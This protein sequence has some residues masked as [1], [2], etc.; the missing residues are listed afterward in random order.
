[1][2]DLLRFYRENNVDLKDLTSSIISPQM[3]AD[4]IVLVEQ[5]VISGKIAKSVFEEMSKTGKSPAAIVE[6]KGLVQISDT[7]AIEKLVDQVIQDN[8]QPVSQYRAGKTGNFGFF[9]G[10][11]MKADRK[12]TRLNSSH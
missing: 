9:V 11:V 10:Q 12:S 1:M 6:E 7:S 2:G 3:L 4:M 5:G 8:P